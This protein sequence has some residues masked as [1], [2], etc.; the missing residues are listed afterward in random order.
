M[1]AKDGTGPAGSGP[2][3]G[4]GQEVGGKGQRSTR[5]GKG[6]KSGGKKGGCK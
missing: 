3:D 2:R 4:R 6:A 1:P 5:K